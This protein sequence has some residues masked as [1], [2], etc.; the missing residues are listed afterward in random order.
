MTNKR[1]FLFTLLATLF[2]SGCGDNATVTKNTD[3]KHLECLQLTLLM[4]DAL[5]SN[6]LKSLYN[7]SENCPYQLQVSRK[8]NIVCNSNQNADRKALSNFPSGY[9]RLDV[10]EGRKNIYSYYRDLDHPLEKKDLTQA[11]KRL[12]SDLL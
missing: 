6:T 11:F 9:I 3:K 12:K 2:I 1:L 5:I 8:N 10:Y 7:F 4:P